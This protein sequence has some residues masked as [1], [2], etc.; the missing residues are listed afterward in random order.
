MTSIKSIL[1]ALLSAV[2]CL[3]IMAGP[4]L[5]GREPIPPNAVVFQLFSIVDIIAALVAGWLV[6]FS[7]KRAKEKTRKRK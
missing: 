7:I 1:I 4:R 2:V 5:W 3:A 6:V